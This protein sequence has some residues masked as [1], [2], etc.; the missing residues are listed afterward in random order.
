MINGFAALLLSIFVH[1]Y[2]STITVS[3]ITPTLTLDMHAVQFAPDITT[4]STPLPPLTNSIA[5]G[6]TTKHLGRGV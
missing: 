6:P 2:V 1:E 4:P 5:S 3:T